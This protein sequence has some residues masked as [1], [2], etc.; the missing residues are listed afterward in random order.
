MFDEQSWEE[1]YRSHTAVWSGRPNPQLV[2]EA[3]DL[4]VGTALD[5]GCGEG[6][7][8]LWLASRG[9][10]VTAVDFSTTALGRAAA[11]AETFGADVAERLRWLHADV[12]TWA[13]RHQFDLVS[14]H[15]M[16]LPTAPR[17]A[18]FARMAALVAPGGT[19]LIVGHHPSDMQT[20]MP[21]PQIPEMFFTA[22]EV[23][24]SLDP[25]Q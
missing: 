2:A 12:T 3:S 14:A 6:A 17:E 4:P 23:A 1:R 18:L 20:P 9:W 21:R 15:F 24:T 5:V 11:H 25:N 19:L 16:H 7:D 13:D 22:E 10:R 8:A